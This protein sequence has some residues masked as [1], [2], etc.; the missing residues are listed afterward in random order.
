MSLNIVLAAVLRAV[1]VWAYTAAADYVAT[2]GRAVHVVI[3][4][5]W[6]KKTGLYSGRLR[7][8]RNKVRKRD[9]TSAHQH[10]THTCK[11]GKVLAH[12]E[13][14]ETLS[15]V[16]VS[17]THLVGGK[18]ALFLADVGCGFPTLKA[19]NLNEDLDKVFVECGLEYRIVKKGQQFTRMHR[20]GDCIPE[21]EEVILVATYLDILFNL[22]LV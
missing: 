9:D 14:I 19:I 13:A 7:S 17:S 15:S 22:L 20:T 6:S 12:F 21:G 8:S 2:R 5:D 1:G 18:R 11:D 10:D 16:D 4:I 3:I